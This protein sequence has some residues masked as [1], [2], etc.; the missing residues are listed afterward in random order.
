[1]GIFKESLTLTRLRHK[2]ALEEA[3]QSIERSKEGMEKEISSELL[4][5]DL[6]SAIDSLR[7]LIGEIYSE[8]LLDVIFQEFCIG[9]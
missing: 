4:L 9:K 3:L 8:D 6:K 2:Q 7:E 1:M 5:L